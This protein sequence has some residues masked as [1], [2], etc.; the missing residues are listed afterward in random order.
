MY[1]TNVVP[2]EAFD[3]ARIL[4]AAAVVVDQGAG[5]T[6]ETVNYQIL[7]GRA[8]RD[9]RLGGQASLARSRPRMACMLDCECR[10]VAQRS[11]TVSFPSASSTL[12]GIA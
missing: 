10:V 3:R 9:E 4:H 2:G 5:S 1:L 6:I 8:E 7:Q 11:H 12:M